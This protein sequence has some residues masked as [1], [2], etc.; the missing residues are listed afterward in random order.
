M[1]AFLD[2]TEIEH[3]ADAINDKIIDKLNKTLHYSN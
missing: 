3:N 1:L 2:I